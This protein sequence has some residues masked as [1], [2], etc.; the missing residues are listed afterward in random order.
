MI[1]LSNSIYVHAKLHLKLSCQIFE[2]FAH[3]L[4]HISFL[5]LQKFENNSNHESF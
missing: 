4:M 1:K 5:T 2:S 3:F